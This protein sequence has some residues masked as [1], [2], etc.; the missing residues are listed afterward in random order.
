LKDPKQQ[1]SEIQTK[2]L[3]L[4]PISQR[5]HAHDLKGR[6]GRLTFVTAIMRLEALKCDINRII[7]NLEKVKCNLSVI[8]SMTPLDTAIFNLLEGKR[9]TLLWRGTEHGFSVTEFHERCN[10]KRNTIT[11]ILDTDGNIFGGFTPL[12]WS[13]RSESLR[14]DSNKSFLFSVK[15]P[16]NIHPIRFQ[17]SSTYSYAIKC[18][19]DYGPMF[20]G[21][22]L[23]IHNNCNVDSKNSTEGFGTNYKNDSPI[24]YSSTFFTGQP[25]FTVQEIEVFEIDE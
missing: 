16:H 21:N 19:P 24:E 11:I 8:K 5:M 3:K 4:E 20:G 15:N 10:N 18:S 17:L 22:D 6:C 2:L 9:I 23:I 12:P 25:K 13:S 1:I 14:D 7:E